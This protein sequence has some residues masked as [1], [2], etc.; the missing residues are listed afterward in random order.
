M[1]ICWR[2]VHVGVKV[3][4]RRVGSDRCWCVE[5][6]WLS[7]TTYLA[8]KLLTSFYTV[9]NDKLKLLPLKLPFHVPEFT[10]STLAELV[11][12]GIKDKL[13]AGEVVY[14]LRKELSVVTE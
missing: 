10:K 11:Q 7:L 2:T 1:E 8:V 14:H 3:S 12:F 13:M 9:H 5:F 6:I 4:S